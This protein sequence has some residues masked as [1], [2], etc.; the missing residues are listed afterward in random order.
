MHNVW[1]VG[2][3]SGIGA[4]CSEA[5]FADKRVNDLSST[6]VETSVTNRSALRAHVMEARFFYD[7]LVYSAR[8]SK[9]CRRS[10]TST[11]GV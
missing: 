4:A 2:G 8:M 11:A 10:W 1:V 9:A 3:T 6:G 7:I 5:L